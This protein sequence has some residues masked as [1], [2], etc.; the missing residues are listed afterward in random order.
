MYK[1]KVRILFLAAHPVVCARMAEAC[2]HDLGPGW[3]ESR[4]ACLTLSHKDPLVRAFSEGNG[5]HEYLLPPA[6]LAEDMLE[7]AD[8]VVTLGGREEEFDLSL[9]PST[10]RKH[11]VLTESVQGHETDEQIRIKLHSI[12]DE[13]KRHVQGIIGGIRLLARSDGGS[14]NSE[15]LSVD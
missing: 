7:W 13:I 9:P 6:L 2:A 15:G 3:L 11:W 5:V 14:S 8:L 10:R 4:S 1:R 12:Q